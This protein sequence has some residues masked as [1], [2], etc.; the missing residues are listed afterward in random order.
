M[1]DFRKNSKELLNGFTLI[2]LLVVI[3]IIAIL[4]AILFP[5]FAQ[6]REKAR[7]ST[8]LSN[9]KQLGLAIQQY[10]S[11]YDQML[12]MDQKANW[13]GNWKQDIQPYVKNLQIFC[14]PSAKSRLTNSMLWN[15]AG[16]YGY[17]ACYLSPY[18]D[19]IVWWVPVSETAINN[20]SETVMITESCWIGT[21]AWD[22]STQ[23]YSPVNW[24]YG[25]INAYDCPAFN[26]LDGA[27]ITWVDGHAKWMKKGSEFWPNDM[28]TMS[29]EQV[30]KLWDLS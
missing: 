7:Q 24:K 29:N 26:H 18:K 20:P 5:V 14:C 10:M 23:V 8:C 17:N 28:A 21:S 2:E 13:A 3:A 22:Y 11:D 9:C 25:W 15:G 12:P 30:D 1:L 4:A 19:N 6:A 16:T 27:N